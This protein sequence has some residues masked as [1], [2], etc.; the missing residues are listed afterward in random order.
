MPNRFNRAE[1]SRIGEVIFF[2]YS[3]VTNWLASKILVC[4][5][6]LIYNVFTLRYLLLAFLF[7]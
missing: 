7:E 1:R 4:L 3:V 6:S 5:F 2:C